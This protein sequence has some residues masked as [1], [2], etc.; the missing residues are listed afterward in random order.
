MAAKFL[1]LCVPALLISQTNI[2]V[3][4]PLAQRAP[5]PADAQS[6]RRPGARR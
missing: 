6:F 1:A 5:N 3:I 4:A 2:I